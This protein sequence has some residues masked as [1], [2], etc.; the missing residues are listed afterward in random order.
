MT[1]MAGV[2]SRSN[3]KPCPRICSEL[4][5]LLSRHKRDKAVELGNDR[6]WIAKVD[7]GAFGS[8]GLA[9]LLT[10]GLLIAAAITYVLARDPSSVMQA[11]NEML[12]R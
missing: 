4:K 8:A 7:I 12:R 6:V 1:I 3:E 10:F 5:N 2:Y 9:G 11:L